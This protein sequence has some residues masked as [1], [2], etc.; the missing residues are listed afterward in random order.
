MWRNSKNMAICNLSR[1][2][3]LDIDLAGT[4]ILDFQSQELW[5]I[6]SCSIESMSMVFCYGRPKLTDI[7]NYYKL[8]W[9]PRHFIK[10]LFE[11]KSTCFCTT[12]PMFTTSLA[13][14]RYLLNEWRNT[15]E[16]SENIQFINKHLGGKFIQVLGSS[17]N[18]G[19]KWR[20]NN[21]FKYI[22][23]VCIYITKLLTAWT[24][25]LAHPTET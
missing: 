23:C 5:E 24:F 15:N 3:S 16:C 4:L 10:H 8:A 22:V 19:L 14:S 7:G 9:V 13:H 2:P 12:L 6:N 17:W 20:K 21:F 11:Q 18:Y 1:G 25:L